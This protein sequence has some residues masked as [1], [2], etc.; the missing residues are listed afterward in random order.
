MG[1]GQAAIQY[2]G[3]SAAIRIAD[4]GRSTPIDQVLTGHDIGNGSVYED[5]S[6]KVTAVGNAH[7]SFHAGL[8]TGKH[9]SYAYRFETP[10]RIIVS[11]GDTG[12]SVGT[13][14]F[15]SA[16]VAIRR[17]FSGAVLVCRGPGE[18]LT[19]RDSPART[20]RSTGAA[21]RGGRAATGS[22][23]KP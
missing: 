16:R 8:A 17:F 2:F 19:C 1:L 5:A 10:D 7:F 12:P 22:S 11:T 20:R 3:I 6:V 14:F 9:E 13:T 18:I 23:R 21:V 15:T 4:G